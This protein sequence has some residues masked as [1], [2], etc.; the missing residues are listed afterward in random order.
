MKQVKLLV[1]G[2]VVLASGAL[3]AQNQQNRWFIGVGAHAV[4]HSSVN[5]A[6]N[7]F[8]FNKLSFNKFFKTKNWS[9]VPP[10]SKLTVGHSISDNLA[11][12]MTASVGA[13][14]NSRW[15]FKDEF[16][17][18]TGL[19]LRFYP[20]ARNAWFDPYLRAGTNYNKFSYNGKTLTTK[21]DGV[22]RTKKKDFFVADGGLGFNIWLAENFGLNIESNYNWIPQGKKDYLNFFQHSAGLV[23]RFGKK[24]EPVVIPLP[25]IV[26]PP[27]VEP[28]PPPVVEPTP[29]PVVEP[30]KEVVAKV[31]HDFKDVFFDLNK[32][33]ICPQSDKHIEHAVELMNQE[34]MKS[35]NFCI[36]GYTDSATGTPAYNYELSKR[37]AHAVRV[38][39]I[40]KGVDVSRLAVEGLGPENPV[41]PN[42]TKEGQEKN[43]RVE[44]QIR[45][46]DCRTP[47]NATK[48]TTYRPKKSK[49]K[50]YS[51]KRVDKAKVFPKKE[52]IKKIK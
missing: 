49:V 43:R 38:A 32:A 39:L 21:K 29:P 16:F 34:G 8:S 35:H 42:N 13:I 4:D 7:K 10:L 23:F 25:L 46:G 5:P 26:E 50:H 40:N 20:F 1:A 37:R 22:Y 24:K 47:S 33:T 45:D 31:N 3:D 11:V 14:D 6:F 2:L 15:N 30:Q 52:V 48:V 51:K 18:K 27:M 17:L 9:V 44:I 36:Y 12:D 28:T 19:G 41:A